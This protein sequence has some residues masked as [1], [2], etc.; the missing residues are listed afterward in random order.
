MLHDGMGRALLLVLLV[1]CGRT[2]SEPPSE[3]E[4]ATVRPAPAS[5]HDAAPR[6]Y[7]ELVDVSGLDAS[8]V[9][10]MRYATTDNFTKVALYPEARCLLRAAVAERLVEV[11][12]KLRARGLGLKL[13]DCYRPF[14]VQQALWKIVPDSRYVARPLERDGA[15]VQGS[16]HNRGAAVDLTLVD[17]AGRELPM[18]SGYDDFSERAH[19]SCEQ[20][21]AEQR[22]NK[23]LLEDAMVAAGFHPLRTEWWHFDGPNW[24]R[25]PLAD[26][27]FE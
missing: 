24:A 1:A 25:F 18:P 6:R 20:C 7:A 4:V 11:Q 5:S 23:N 9:I 12:R 26:Q 16:R 13:W 14:S 10:E 21:S 27:P 22:A 19:R 2:A 15:P 8:L 3:I 17:H